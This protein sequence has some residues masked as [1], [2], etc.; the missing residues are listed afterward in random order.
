[1]RDLAEVCSLSGGAAAPIR[2]VTGRRWLARRSSTHIPMAW[3]CGLGFSREREGY[4][5]TLFLHVRQMSG[6]GPVVLPEGVVVCE[7]NTLKVPFPPSYLLVK[8]ISVF[9]LFN[10]TTF[11]DSSL[12]V[13]HAARAW[14][15]DRLDAG[16]EGYVVPEASHVQITS[17]ACPG[18]PQSAER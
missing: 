7:W 17:D 13:D 11:I 16:S 6:L 9:G 14:R 4:G 5:L 18:R 2:P 8:P 1:M 10:M 3:P 12:Y 15:P